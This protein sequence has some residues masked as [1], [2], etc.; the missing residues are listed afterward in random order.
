MEECAKISKQRIL[1]KCHL[2][3]SLRETLVLARY[4]TYDFGTIK[5]SVKG[6]EVTKTLSDN[7]LNSGDN[8][9]WK[10]TDSYTD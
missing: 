2:C 5:N 6:I 8:L 7:L 3:I 4:K 9:F 1:V 10:Q